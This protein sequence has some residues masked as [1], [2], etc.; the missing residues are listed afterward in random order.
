MSNETLTVVIVAAVAPSGKA[1]TSL[2]PGLAPSGQLVVLAIAE[3]L[4]IPIM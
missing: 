4:V 3:D 1:I 2:I